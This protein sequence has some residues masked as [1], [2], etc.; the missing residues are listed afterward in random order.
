MHTLGFIGQGWIGRNLANHF[1]ER[2]FPVVRY[3]DTPEFVG[4]RDAIAEC[5]IVFI[6]VPTPS[7]PEGFDMSI[8]ESVLG[9][10]GEG[11]IAVIKS[12]IL[13]GTTDMLARRHQR[14]FILHAPEFLRETSVR[15][16]IDH[17]DRNIVGI[18]GAHLDDARW[19]EAAETV[20]S[21][22]PSAPYQSL[23]SAA[24]AELTK[25]GGNNFLYTK[26]VFMNMLY[27]L[28]VHHGARFEE[29]ARNMS[30]DP[31]IG[32][33]HMRP[34]HQYE[35]M[36]GQSGRG[37]GGHCF[38]KDFAALRE[39][40]VSMLPNDSEGIALLLALEAKNN[41]LLR[42]SGK[43]LDLLHGVYGKLGDDMAEMQDYTQK[44][45]DDI[46]A[47]E[48]AYEKHDLAT[49]AAAYDRAGRDL[50]ELREAYVNAGGDLRA[51]SALDRTN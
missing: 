23:C 7:T 18:P 28:S 4:N 37:A 2:G 6:A 46:T 31:R 29:V 8:L 35:H 48:R 13:P 24:E 44:E 10:V 22:L 5:D 45:K 38:I 42:D 41:R 32:A 11:K 50:A 39:Q 43:D 19:Q 40:Y 16:D 3:A 15:H 1:E 25:Y 51:L 30:A 47:M 21:V 34:V 33:S 27:D 26:V 17:P 9:L 12:T 14:T 20:L 36:G 49:L